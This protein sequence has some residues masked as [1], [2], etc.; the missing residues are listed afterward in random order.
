MKAVI[1]AGGKGRRMRAATPDRPKPMLQLHGKPILEHI[2]ERLRQ[3]GISEFFIVTGFRAEI[4]EEYFGTG[5]RSGVSI[6]YGRQVVQDGTG[7]AP[8]LAKAFVGT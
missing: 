6:R 1:W 3:N 4:V 5:E 2:I 8:E 7:K